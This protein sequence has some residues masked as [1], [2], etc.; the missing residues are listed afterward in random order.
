M[1]F[2]PEPITAMAETIRLQ[3]IHIKS[4][5]NPHDDLPVDMQ[6]FAQ[7]IL[8]GN[9]FLQTVPMDSEESRNSWKL[10]VECNIPSHMPTFSVAILRQ[11]KT[12]GKRLLGSVDIGKG[13]V[14]KAMESNQR[15]FHL[16]LNKVNPDGPS[17]EFSGGFS[18]SDAA[19]TAILR[20]NV[21]DTLDTHIT[22]LQSPGILDD[23]RRIRDGMSSQ[24]IVDP[25]QLSVMHERILLLPYR[26]SK[27]ARFLKILG[28][29]S[30][31]CYMTSGAVSSL[32]HAVSAYDDAV[33]DDPRS[34]AYMSDL[35]VALTKRFER[36]GDLADLSRQLDNL[37]NLLLSR[38]EHG[39]DLND[40]NEAVSKFE[41]AVEL[42]P[43]GHPDMPKHLANLGT[44]LSRRFERLG[45]LTDINTAVTKFQAAVELTPDGHPS[46]PSRLG[47]LGNSLSRRFEHLGDFSD[48]TL[49]VSKFEAAVELVPS[50]HP[51]MSRLLFNLGNVLGR[52]FGRLGD[53]TDINQAVSNF[54]DAVKITPDGHRDMPLLLTNLGTSLSHRFE[55]IGDLRDINEAVSKLE[56][57]VEFTPDNHPDLSSRLSRLGDLLLSRFERFG[58]L[59]DINRAVLQYETVVGLTADGHPDMAS[60]LSKVGNCLLS[61]FGRLGDLPDIH[62]VVSTLEAAVALTPETH[63][64]MPRQLNNLGNSLLSR[65]EHIGNLT[66]INEAVSKYKAAVE[67][68]P[69]GDQSKPST[70]TN[71]GNS[72]RIRFERLGELPDINEAVLKLEMAVELTPDGHPDMARYLAN[73]GISLSRRFERLG[74]LA[75]LTQAVSKYET[76]AG[77]TADSHPDMPSHLT[78]LGNSLSRRFEHVGDLTDINEALSKFMAAVELT[79]DNHPDMP[80]HLTCLGNSLL[81]RFERFGDLTD[82]T[83]AV[84]KYETAVGLTADGHPDLPLRLSNLGTSLLSRF[85]RLGDIADI[86]QAVS[87]LEAAIECTPEGHP[88]TPSVLNNLGTSLHCRFARSE[89]LTDI[90]QAVLRLEAAVELTP[91]GHP[92]LPSRLNNLGNSLLSRC[93]HSSDHTDINQAISKLDAAIKLTPVGHPYMPLWQNNLGNSLHH[94]FR[95]LHDPDDHDKMLI[96]YTQAASSPTG[97]AQVRFQAAAMWATSAETVQHPSLLQAYRTAINLLPELAWLGLSISDRHHQILQAG[98]VVRDAASAAIA[99]NQLSMAVEWLEQG[100][101]VIWG[102]IL[103]LR[104]PVDDLWKLHPNLADELVSYS[105]RLEAAGIKSRAKLGRD[106]G[107]SLSLKTVAEDSHTLADKRAR[108]LEQIRKLAGFE[109]FLLPKPISELSLSAMMGP[110]VL[111]NITEHRCDALILMAGLRDQVLHVPLPHFTS[112][113]ARSMA[114]SLGSI[115]SGAARSQR[116]DGF[117]EEDIPLNEQ[118]SQMLSTLWNQIVK[119]VLDGKA[120]LTPSTQDLGRIWWCPTGPLVFLPIHAAGLYGKDKGF[121]SKLSDFFISSYTPSLTALIEGFRDRQESKERL[122]ILAVAQPST[123]GAGYIPGT[124]KEIESIHRLSTIPI[125]RLERDLATVDSVKDGMKKSRWAH[126]ACHGVQDIFNPTNSA[127]LL[128]HNSRLTLSS[129]IQLSLPDT[130]LAFLSACQTAT[131]SKSLE[132]ES[133]HLTAGM[134]LAGYRGVIG[135]MWAIKDNDAPK[136]AGDV[137]AHLFKTSPPD[138]RRAAEALHLAIGKLRD[139]DMAGGTESF[140]HWVPFIHVGV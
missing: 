41:A 85:E 39:G 128:A 46:K 22:S 108:L 47:N 139:S 79:P 30:L 124:L 101:S 111:L 70:L 4:R 21:L 90:N 119:P 113:D 56:A 40:I 24:P 117:Q 53:L 33:R 120:F 81:S 31:R 94:R 9:I 14:I 50:G 7:L 129:I 13:E 135:T 15:G 35:D 92:D 29:I 87:K 84:S 114:K 104:T 137:Y 68:T 6:M 59:T 11:C 19:T 64:N 110:V 121:G 52:R 122:Q 76:A 36:V 51:V 118:F 133:V 42:T 102:Q 69:D 96:Q 134:L 18:V 43:D 103:N 48:I 65:F 17:L 26:Q 106:A 12:G 27:R 132:D 5:T 66:D 97:P 23:L 54:E 82:L 8:E 28:D 99:A 138:S 60:R 95:Q 140:S 130:D 25:L 93:E 67:I 115:V 136:V 49:A 74:D 38:F 61:R 83:Q 126:F 10:D 123:I 105:T 131:G 37:G 57:A 75:D 89:D 34:A 109:R 112:Q 73:L 55:R 78:N 77:I 116:L 91:A 107:S 58:D 16:E 1:S 63:P 45:D 88:E 86:D 32:N 3:S 20:F 72:L 100:R 71:L 125:L 127:L 98:R 62:R 2:L 44:S 80:T